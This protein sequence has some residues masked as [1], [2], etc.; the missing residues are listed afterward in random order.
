MF[1]ILAQEVTELQ[2]FSVLNCV[3]LM[4]NDGVI[5]ERLISLMASI[6]CW[7]NV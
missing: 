7:G 5:W 2:E 3:E 6:V 4:L 1:R